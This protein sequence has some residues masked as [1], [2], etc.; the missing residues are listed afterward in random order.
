MAVPVAS[1][2]R[3]LCERSQWSLSNLALQKILYLAHMV[4]LGWTD[5]PLIDSGFEA[6]DYGP[7]QPSLYHKVK[8]FGSSPIKD[9]F[10]DAHPLIDQSSEAQ[11]LD[12]A[13]EHFGGLSPG[14]LV[15]ITHHAGGAWDKHYN[16][17]VRGLPIP[18]RD[19]RKEYQ[20][21][22]AAN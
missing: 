7:V 12:A 8:V 19:I 1:A 17:S 14:K 5:N 6:W 16:P 21:I 11:A 4:H 20:E 13:L 15:A 3:R 9:I 10:H 18:D 22:V 2:A